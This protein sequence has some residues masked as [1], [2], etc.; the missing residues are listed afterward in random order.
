MN[1]LEYTGE[2]VVPGKI[3]RALWHEHLARYVFAAHFVKDRTVLDAG[4]GCGYGAAF[5]AARG[6]ARV[7]GVDISAEAIAYARAHYRRD[8]LEYRVSDVVA[9]DLGDRM[10]DVVVSFEVIEHLADAEKFLAEVARVLKEE[11]LFLVSTPNRLAYRRGQEPNPFHT[12]EFDGDEFRRLLGRFFPRVT[13]L[14][15]DHFT[16]I[17]FLPTEGQRPDDEGEAVIDRSLLPAEAHHFYFLALCGGA[18]SVP[19]APPRRLVQLPHVRDEYFDYLEW[20]HRLDL[21]MEDIARAVP[22]G[23]TFVLIDQDEFGRAPGSGRRAIPFLE[24]DW[25]YWGP[26][27]D[28]ATAIGELE[29]LRGAGANFLV[30]GWPAFWWLEHYTDFHRYLRANFRPICENERIIIFD[31]RPGDGSVISGPQ[32]G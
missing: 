5:L 21:V 29:R 27:P 30:V 3:D 11:G 10:F 6:A 19:A 7:L 18:A 1:D 25:Q 13:I 26:P 20:I 32:S 24:R 23:E 31:L 12:R 2:R 4:C 14:A 28:D 22:P 15:Q 16:A 8:N 17:A 9:L